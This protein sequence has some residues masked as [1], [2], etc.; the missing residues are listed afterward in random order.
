MLGRAVPLLDIVF[1]LYAERARLERQ[2]GVD[3]LGS[4]SVVDVARYLEPVDD[5]V[6]AVFERLSSAV[7]SERAS[8]V[9]TLVLAILKSLVELQW[10]VHTSCLSG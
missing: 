7:A 3:P 5:L 2:A 10:C 1:R 4:E 8:L 9:G 6:L